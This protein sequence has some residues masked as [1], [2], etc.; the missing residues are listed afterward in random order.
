MVTAHGRHPFR[1][2]QQETRRQMRHGKAKTTEQSAERFVQF[3]TESPPLLLH[4][5]FEQG[6][7]IQLERPAGQDIQVFIRDGTVMR[8]NN[9]CQS[10]RAVRQRPFCADAGEITLNLLRGIGHSDSSFLLFAA[11]MHRTGC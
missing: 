11:A 8:G 2:A 1:L 7:R 5:F 9:L 3:E 10:V 6:L 4:D